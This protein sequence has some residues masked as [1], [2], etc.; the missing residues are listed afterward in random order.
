ME[1]FTHFTSEKTKTRCLQFNTEAIKRIKTNILY[2]YSLQHGF[3]A[4]MYL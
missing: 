2:I 3:L 1:K 4:Y